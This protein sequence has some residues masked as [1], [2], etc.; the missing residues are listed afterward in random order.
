M[1]IKTW[2]PVQGFEGEALKIGTMPPSSGLEEIGAHN[3]RTIVSP[4][5]LEKLVVEGVR[6]VEKSDEEA[7][8]DCADGI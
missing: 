8:G 4:V 3:Q 1:K 2:H 7:I 6:D 5:H